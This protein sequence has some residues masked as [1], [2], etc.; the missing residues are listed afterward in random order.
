MLPDLIFNL[1]WHSSRFIQFS[2]ASQILCSL[3]NDV[4]IRIN[5]SIEIYIDIY[6]QMLLSF[7]NFW[8]HK[9]KFQQMSMCNV[10]HADTI[11][12]AINY[13]KGVD[14]WIFN[15]CKNIVQW[16]CFGN[17]QLDDVRLVAF[18]LFTN[19]HNMNVYLQMT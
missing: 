3:W 9:F 16:V 17:M 1:C 2:F 15:M 6:A 14:F 4:C 7:H 13:N 18:L 10:I 19:I 12:K 5:L 11:W 8:L